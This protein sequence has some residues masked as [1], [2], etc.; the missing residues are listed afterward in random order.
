[1]EPGYFNYSFDSPLIRIRKLMILSLGRVSTWI[2]CSEHEDKDESEFMMWKI[3]KS[4]WYC[5][6]T[7]LNAHCRRNKRSSQSW[8][9]RLDNAVFILIFTMIYR[10]HLTISQF[11]TISNFKFKL[12]WIRS[13]SDF[14]LNDLLFEMCWL[15]S[16]DGKRKNIWGVQFTIH[17][18]IRYYKIVSK[19]N[20]KKAQKSCW[21]FLWRAREIFFHFTFLHSNSSSSSE[22]FSLFVFCWYLVRFL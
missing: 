13:A 2:L 18:S 8:F 7:L 1:M 19:E 16:W 22:S 15:G 3:F 20:I 17:D 5:F 21:K 4:F 11:S 14:F 12:F 6:M 9:S 10:L